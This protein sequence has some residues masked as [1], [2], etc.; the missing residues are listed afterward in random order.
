[1]SGERIISTVTGGITLEELL[2]LM[3]DSIK[4]GLYF[5]IGPEATRTLRDAFVF[6][7]VHN[8]NLAAVLGHRACGSAEHDPLSGKIHGYCI[9]C[10]IPWPCE[11][12]QAFLRKPQ[13][14]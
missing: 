10:Q 6:A 2:Q 14:S 9:V 4:D 12:A 13:Q 1:M 7:S 3:N 5:E 11:T 8:G